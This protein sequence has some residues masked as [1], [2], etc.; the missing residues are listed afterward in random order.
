[1]LVDGVGELF[2]LKHAALSVIVFVEKCGE[3]FLHNLL[4]AFAA[5]ILSSL[6]T[7]HEIDKVWEANLTNSI[8]LN[9][10][11]PVNANLVDEG[12]CDFVTLVEINHIQRLQNE[13]SLFLHHL[14]LHTGVLS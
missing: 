1:L 6:D 2:D 14:L 7:A 3:V 10:Q 9:E 13:H 5:S 8:S 4:L 12:E 11:D